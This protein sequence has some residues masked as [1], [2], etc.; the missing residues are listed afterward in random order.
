MDTREDRQ[1]DSGVNASSESTP[2]VVNSDEQPAAEISQ[3]EQKMTPGRLLVVGCILV[4]ELCERMTF[5]S[6][7]ANMV[8]FC[9]SVL[10]FDSESAS[11]ITQVFGGTVALFP[12]IGGYVSDAFLGKFRTILIS[13]TIYLIGLILLPASAINYPEWFKAEH[14]LSIEGR[15]S[16]FFLALVFIAIGTGGIKA[17]VGPFGAQ[18]VQDLGPKAL[19]SFFNWFYWF[20]NAG[21][22]IA[23]SAV[24]Y[25]QQEKGFDVGFIIP[26][27][28]MVVAVIMFVVARGKYV[29]VP[30]R[31]SV[32]FK[33]INVC[34]K[35]CHKCKDP[36]WDHAINKGY[37]D[38]FV[39]G[40]RAATRVIPIFLM[41]IV[42]WA[43][44]SQMSSTLY[45]QS[46]RMN[47]F[48]GDVKM[49]AALLSIFDTI[50]ILILIPLM[51]IIYRQLEKIDK[52]PTH[53]QRIGIGMVFAVC[54]MLV[55]GVIEMVRKSDIEKHGGFP[56]ELAGSTFN[57]SNIS[58][59]AQVPEFVLIGT[60][61]VFTSIS[62]LEFA[63]T[64]APSF[65]QGLLMG[66]FLM[67]SGLG[68][69]VASLIVVIASSWRTSDASDWYPKEPN[70]GHLEYFLY[71][72]AVLTALNLC[73]FIIVAKRYKYNNP[74]AGQVNDDN[75]D[76]N[77]G[78]KIII[79]EAS[80]DNT[81]NIDH[82]S[83]EVKSIA[84][85]NYG[86]FETNGKDNNTM[87]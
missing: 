56:Q 71:L 18:Q 66:M 76:G 37:D 73:V 67:T 69:Y 65:M 38:G 54:A 86:T 6:V 68:G 41:I 39:Y 58:V 49:P 83:T 28:S 60:S 85:D 16:L 57:A 47:L 61:E 5:Y 25:V 29:Q 4:T 53:L 23:F 34:C 87:T 36:S 48:V 75:N 82:E 62:G 10:K 44:Y 7:T 8:L 45:L 35:A 43:V 15:K 51:E 33:S 63:Y 72:L 74:E 40:V 84:S 64:Q 3:T 30:P 1:D 24:A 55:S 2:L 59:F 50:I 9:T 52:N 27:C 31:G 20:I 81:N 14:H 79:I 11:L 78:D 42:Y 19:Q 12:V 32:L 46:E 80:N 26:L 21:S 17:N 13:A 77:Y 22:I 70:N